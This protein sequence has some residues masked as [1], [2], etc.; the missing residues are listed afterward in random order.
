MLPSPAFLHLISCSNIERGSRLADLECRVLMKSISVQ[1]GELVGCHTASLPQDPLAN[2][3]L[4]YI[5]SI[6]VSLEKG[7]LNA[8]GV[9]ISDL[10]WFITR[11]INTGN[12][13][14]GGVLGGGEEE[15][16]R[17]DGA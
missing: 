6:A 8:A 15:G 12:K 17:G 16:N 1:T 4:T 13:T 11:E 10:H 9:D 3:W 5:Y 2:S 14:S 7:I